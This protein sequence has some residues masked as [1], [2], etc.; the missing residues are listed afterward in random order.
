MPTVLVTRHAQASFGA[1]DYDVLSAHGHTQAAALAADL[2]RRGIGIDRVVS[3]SLTRQRDTAAPVAASAGHPLE[4]DP[5]W[6]EYD[7]DDILSSYSTSAARAH[8]P[9]DSSAPA[10]YP[11]EFQDLLEPAL[12]AWIAAGDQGSTAETWPAFL[13]RVTGALHDVVMSLGPGQTALVCT[14]GGALAATC[15]ATLGLPHPAFL[16]LNRVAV[17]TGVTKVVHGRSGSTL[18]SFNDH[19]HL[20]RPD[21][22]LITYR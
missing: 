18:I 19:G 12:L 7:T 2:R 20:E 3:G 1:E 21:G 14:S 11:R 4:T 17:N 5:R 9:A 8:R 6:D 22:D 10:V 16:T 15:V 13:A